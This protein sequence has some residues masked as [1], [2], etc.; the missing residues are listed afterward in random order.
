MEM[1]MD[2]ESVEKLR[3]DKRLIGRRGWI[4]EE[5]L[6]RAL[7]SLPDAADKIAPPETEPSDSQGSDPD[8]SA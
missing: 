4:D 3:L 6:K 5:E 1:T 7:D 2:R 8:A